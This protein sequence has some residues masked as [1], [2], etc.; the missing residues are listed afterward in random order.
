MSIKLKGVGCKISRISFNVYL[1]IDR[2]KK[3]ECI[4]V[5]TLRAIENDNNLL[6]YAVPFRADIDLSKFYRDDLDIQ[7]DVRVYTR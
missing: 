4:R 6:I 1:C 7:L 3:N 2:D 5:S